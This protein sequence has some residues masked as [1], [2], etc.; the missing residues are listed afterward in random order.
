MLKLI[1][2]IVLHAKPSLLPALCKSLKTPT[3]I[4]ILHSEPRETR[5]GV[6]W[7]HCLCV[8]LSQ[9]ASLYGMKAPGFIDRYVY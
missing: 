9:R 7:W 2:K 3:F 8:L 5:G 4:F 1:V 6:G